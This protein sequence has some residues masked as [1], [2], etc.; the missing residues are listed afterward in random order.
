MVICVDVVLSVAVARTVYDVMLAPLLDGAVHVTVAD[1]DDA[2]TDAVPTV[3]V[4]GV[5]YGVMEDDELE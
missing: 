2:V 4:P 3:G 1:V 5:V